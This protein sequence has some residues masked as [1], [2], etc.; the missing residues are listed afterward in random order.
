MKMKLLK[1]FKL[2]IFYYLLIFNLVIA[3]ISVSQTPQYYNYNNNDLGNAFPF[4]VA[5]GKR[6]QVLYRAGEFN[7][8][9]PAVAGNISRVSFRI[10][11]IALGPFTYS[12][13]VIKMGQT[14]LINL[15][16]GGWYNGQLDTVYYRPTVTLSSPAAEW[17]T[18]QLDR[19]FTYDPSQ[20][21]IVD[22]QQCGAPGASSFSS[23][24]TV[25]SGQVRR[26]S[27]SAGTSCPFIWG[28]STAIVHSFGIT[29]I[30]T[31]IQNQNILIPSAYSLFQNYPNPFNPSTN[32]RY[33]IPEISFVK[34]SVY[35][36]LG[37]EI[38]MLV[39]KLQN[40]GTYEVTFENASLESGVY[41]YKLTTERFTDT[42][43]MLLLK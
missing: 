17:L 40:A 7:Q 5:A 10:G 37:R 8:P 4:N 9:S 42:K 24:T 3:N 31:G 13:F 23:A 32:I 38:L 43:Q 6:I 29:L 14:D 2:E 27:S 22:V 11:N 41:L 35:D 36:I 1:V 30:I 26:N 25:H 19:Q 33:D 15:V 18:F 21:L 34:L 39:N 16:S 12:D 20:S 28:E